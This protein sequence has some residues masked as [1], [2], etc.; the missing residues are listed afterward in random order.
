L[1][2]QVFGPEGSESILGPSGLLNQDYIFV[3]G[4]LDICADVRQIRRSGF[5]GKY[6]PTGTHQARKIQGHVPDV[7]A[8]IED[9]IP[10]ADEPGAEGQTVMISLAAMKPVTLVPK[11]MQHNPF[12]SPVMSDGYIA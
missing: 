8:N 7:P 9:Y 10:I 11:R 5:E 4:A 1:A 12:A 2:R 6:S 3:R